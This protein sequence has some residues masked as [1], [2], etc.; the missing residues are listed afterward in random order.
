MASG[1]ILQP[2][3][4]SATDATAGW[5]PD[6][7]STLL[8]GRPRT[9]HYSA[10]EWVSVRLLAQMFELLAPQWEMQDNDVKIQATTPSWLAWAGGWARWPSEVPL[11]LN[12]S[13]ILWKFCILQHQWICLPSSACQIFLSTFLCTAV[14]ALHSSEHCEIVPSSLTTLLLTNVHV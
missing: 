2:G 14:T 12:P 1:R 6:R 11:N 13:V 5:S 9:S 8:F 4:V 3:Q 7:N 10:R